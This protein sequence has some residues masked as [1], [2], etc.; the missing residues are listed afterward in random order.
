MPGA[1]SKAENRLSIPA[2]VLVGLPPIAIGAGFYVLDGGDGVLSLASTV[3]VLSGVLSALIARGLSATA[4]PTV[5]RV[6]DVSSPK[7]AAMTPDLAVAN[8]KTLEA[9]AAADAA[10]QRIR[11]ASQGFA[12][13][14]TEAIASVERARD[15]ATSGFD[16]VATLNESISGLSGS[17]TSIGAR[18]GDG[19]RL[20][21]DVNPPAGS[22][23]HHL[24]RL[25]DA[26]A[27]IGNTLHGIRSISEQ[28]NL[29]ALNAAI[30]AAHAGEAGRG[31]AVVASEVRAMATETNRAS[32]EIAALID[33]MQS[34]TSA[35]TITTR[36]LEERLVAISSTN[37]AIVTVVG[38]QKEMLG[39]LKDN[40]TALDD[41]RTSLGER[42]G[43]V[44][45]ALE[46]AQNEAGRLVTDADLLH[47]MVSKPAD[48]LSEAAEMRRR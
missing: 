47:A 34:A 44:F 29:L 4:A 24:V 33:T 15:V 17:L 48:Q 38:D 19:A 26:V 27:R 20:A 45:A 1:V 22:A 10:Y 2:C 8:A 25:R 31:F 43:A 40:V 21:E 41:W 9:S 12:R 3:V 39:A 13:Q 14:I 42:C 23:S 46:S 28:T 35:A 18:A 32:D 16:A 30:E 6:D 37:A 36:Q 7:A 11:D 5:E